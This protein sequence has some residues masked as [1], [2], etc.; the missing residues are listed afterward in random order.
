MPEWVLAV[1]CSHYEKHPRTEM[2][3]GWQYSISSLSPMLGLLRRV[4]EE[5]LILAL[6]PTPLK[7]HMTP[8]VGGWFPSSYNIWFLP[9]QSGGGEFCLARTLLPVLIQVRA[10]QRQ[11]DAH[12]DSLGSEPGRWGSTPCNGHSGQSNVRVGTIGIQSWG[13]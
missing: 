13:K 1:T 11:G 8:H 6:M 4:V 10:T 5:N 3:Q 7:S 2:T 12:T 9:T